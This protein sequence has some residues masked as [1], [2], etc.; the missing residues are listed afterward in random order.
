MAAGVY[1]I[2][3]NMTG[4]RYIGSSTN[5]VS[6]LA[7]HLAMLK[8]GKH[9]SV[10]LQRAWNKYGEF[11]FEFK[12]LAILEDCEIL[13]TEQRLLDIEHSGET[14]NVAKDAVA[15]MKGRKHSKETIESM[16]KSRMGNKSRTGVPAHWSKDKK[17]PSLSKLLASSKNPSLE[18]KEKMRQAKLGVVPI[19]KGIHSSSCRN[20]HTRTEEN[21]YIYKKKSGGISYNC[22]ICI[23]NIKENYLE[24]KQ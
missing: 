4:T 21:T 16:S 13:P 23:K 11:V 20:G 8:K 18:T 1:A 9:H 6:R 7:Q 17:P 5:I 12:T 22:K 3:N 10:Y 14:Y 15:W 24:R 19:N 2:T